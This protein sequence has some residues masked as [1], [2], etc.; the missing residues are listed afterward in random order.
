MLAQL[1][2]RLS[3]NNV[4]ESQLAYG[5]LFL[6]YGISKGQHSQPLSVCSGEV[7][8][9]QSISILPPQKLER[10]YSYNLT[11]KM[12]SRVGGRLRR[13]RVYEYG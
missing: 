4:D 3:R 8:A 2:Q 11:I 5:D 10:F 9:S 13:E 1:G 12:Y 6:S 7:R